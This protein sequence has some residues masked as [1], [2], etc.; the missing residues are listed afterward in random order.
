[1]LNCAKNL[2]TSSFLSTACFTNVQ[3]P[4]RRS[5]VF[6]FALLIL[7]TICLTIQSREFMYI[8]MSEQVLQS[9]LANDLRIS[10][11]PRLI[12]LTKSI[13]LTKFGK[14][15]DDKYHN[16]TCKIIDV[17]FVQI[18]IRKLYARISTQ[19]AIQSRCIT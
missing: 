17:I 5:A 16:A 7:K 18:A 14:N 1:M 19:F 12:K 2:D 10:Y 13:L 6:D 15:F 3:H 9:K 8:F 4:V 11:E